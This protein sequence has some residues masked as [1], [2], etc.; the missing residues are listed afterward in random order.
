[1]LIMR[2]AKLSNK[3]LITIGYQPITISFGI[4]FLFFSNS[5]YFLKLV[6]IL[7]LITYLDDN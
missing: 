5:F 2:N 3:W 1:M 4:L 6:S 7:G